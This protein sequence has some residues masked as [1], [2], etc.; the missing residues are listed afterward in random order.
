MLPRACA[1][2]RFIFRTADMDLGRL[3]T[4]FALL[5]LPRMPELPAGNASGLAHFT[6]SPVD[7]GTVKVLA[8]ELLGDTSGPLSH[9]C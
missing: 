2:C 8:W 7:P 4:A 9:A 3:A 5:R 6:P 1:Q